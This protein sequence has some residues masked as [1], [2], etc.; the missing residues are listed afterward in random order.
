VLAPQAPAP[1]A[2]WLGLTEAQRAFMELRKVSP[3]E[4]FAAHLFAPEHFDAPTP[5]ER[6]ATPLPREQ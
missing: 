1:P 4:R 3:R 2:F 6:D 5:V